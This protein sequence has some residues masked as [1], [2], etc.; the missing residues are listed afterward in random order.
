MIKIRVATYEILN[1]C[2]IKLDYKEYLHEPV[3]K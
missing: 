2:Y 3:N 1:M